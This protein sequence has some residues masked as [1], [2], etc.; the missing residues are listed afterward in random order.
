M[1]VFAGLWFAQ[2]RWQA[3][4]ALLLVGFQLG[5]TGV[6][7]TALRAATPLSRVGLAISL[8]G[9]APSLGFALGPTVGGWLVDHGVFN[10]HTLFALDAAMSLA[11]G[12]LLLVIG[13]DGVRPPDLQDR[14][15]GSPSTRSGQL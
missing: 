3:A 8:F 15:A 12:L 6:M 7:L 2:N 10:L 1:V 11:A 14:R 9:V 5:N 4:L 13:R